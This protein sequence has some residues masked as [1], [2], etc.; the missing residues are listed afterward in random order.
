ME[1]VTLSHHIGN[2]L[3]HTD[4]FSP[5]WKPPSALWTLLALAC[6]FRVIRTEEGDLAHDTFFTFFMLPRQ[7][8]SQ[9]TGMHFILQNSYWTAVKGGWL[10]TDM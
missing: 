6:F 8:R 7:S 2:Q 4:M 3:A 10:F 9:R 5:H 1:K